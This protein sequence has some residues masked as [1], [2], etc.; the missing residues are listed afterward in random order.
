[1]FRT[2]FGRDALTYD[3][4]N[5]NVG[6]VYDGL[7]T[8]NDQNWSS[9]TT[10]LSA[11]W[12]GFNDV[13][14]GIAMYEYSIGSNPGGT[15]ILTWTENSLETYFTTGVALTSG[16]DYF[17]SVR[18]TDGAGNVSNISTSNGI[19]IDAVDPVVSDVVEGDLN[20]DQDYQQSGSES[21]DSM[22]WV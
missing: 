10:T 14:G 20:T 18:A 12:A 5:P 9:S 21:C 1:M 16:E 7:D 22:G 4:T 13:T 8:Q 19:T 3:V 15:D 2:I 11:N 17:V 6:Y